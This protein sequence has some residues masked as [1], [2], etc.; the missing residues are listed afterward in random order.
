MD[1]ALAIDGQKSLILMMDLVAGFSFS[2]YQNRVMFFMTVCRT[3]AKRTL[4]ILRLL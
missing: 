4:S 3:H 2:C 1:K